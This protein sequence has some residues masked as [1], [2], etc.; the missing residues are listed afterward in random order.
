MTTQ[1]NNQP[2]PRCG[3]WKV[4]GVTVDALF[5]QGGKIL[6]MKRKENPYAGFWALPGGWLEQG[7]TTDGAALDEAWQETRIRGYN[8][9][10]VGVFDDPKRHPEQAISIA[11][12]FDVKGSSV[13]SIGDPKEVEAVEWWP[14]NN[15][16]PLAFDHAKIIATYL[17]RR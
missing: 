8:K 14:L 4:R 16:P 13:P 12:A 15:L 7:Q 10:L 2:C 3:R 1:S 17:S 11:W 6:L 9:R 5:V